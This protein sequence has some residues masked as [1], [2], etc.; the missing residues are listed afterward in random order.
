MEDVL[1]LRT[2]LRAYRLSVMMPMSASLS[3]TVSD[4]MSFSAILATAS[5]TVASGPMEQTFPPF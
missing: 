3:I 2:T 5:N 4:P 1:P